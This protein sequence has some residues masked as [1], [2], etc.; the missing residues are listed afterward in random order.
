MPDIR[1]GDLVYV[2]SGADRADRLT[3]E[4][5]EHTTPERLKQEAE[6][7]PGTRGRVLRVLPA[8]GRV[9]VEGVRTQTKHARPR[10]RTTRVGQMQTGRISQPG[11]IPASKVMLVCPRCNRPTRVRGGEVEGKHVRICRGCAEPVDQV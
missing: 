4:Q 11:P 9:I 5:V 6:K 8:Q 10:G 1:R 2:L 7:H 3:E